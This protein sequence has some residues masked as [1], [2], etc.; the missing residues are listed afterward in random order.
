MEDE[1]PTVSVR[2]WRADAIVLFDWLM[3][4]DLD[5]VPVTHPA[6]KQALADL[7]SRLEWAADADVTGATAE[8]IAAAQSEVARDMGW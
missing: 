4:T 1:L 2:L 6:Q 3:T 5:S 7:L 8:D